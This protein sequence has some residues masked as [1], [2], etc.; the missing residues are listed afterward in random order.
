MQ[1]KQPKFKFYATL[2]DAFTSYLK[3][4]AIWERYGDS[5]RIPTYPRRVQTAAVS[6]PD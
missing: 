3:S 1:T 4:D 6:E 2:L 5:V